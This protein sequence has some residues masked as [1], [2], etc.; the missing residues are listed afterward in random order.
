MFTLLNT[1]FDSSIILQPEGYSRD[2]PNNE[3]PSFCLPG[4]V[5]LPGLTLAFAKRLNAFL[6]TK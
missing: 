5:C 2:I 3:I 4:Q 1:D 6:H